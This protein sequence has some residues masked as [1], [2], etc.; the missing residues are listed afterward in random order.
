MSEYKAAI[1]L[2]MRVWELGEFGLIDRIAGIVAELPGNDVLVGIGDDAAAWLAGGSVQLGTADVLIEDVHFSLDRA[3]WRDLGWKALAISISDI[4]AMGGVP[5]YAMVCLGLPRETEVS[6]VEELYRGML[7]IGALLDVA[8]VGGNV[9]KAPSVVI[10]VSMIGSAS[11]ELLR[12][13][14]A[15]P[16]DRVAVTGCLGQSAAG[17][18][19]LDSEIELNTEASEFFRAAHLRPCPRVREGT[20]L[21]QQGVKAAIDLSDGLVSDLSQL[22]RSSGTSGIIFADRLPVHPLVA[23]TFPDSYRSLALTGGEDYELLFTAASEVIDRV[24]GSMPTGIAVVG[25][26]REGDCGQVTVLD[27]NGNVVELEEKG[28]EHFRSLS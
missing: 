7:D 22:C 6:D 23:S 5:R 18:R 21:A 24:R 28:W 10:D 20:I 26:I 8:I 13:S 11:G 15:L 16:G 14:A 2:S 25:E 4:A 3:T 17:L 9:S 12:R 27:D 19:V 1:M